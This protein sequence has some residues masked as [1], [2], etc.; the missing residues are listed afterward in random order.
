MLVIPLSVLSTTKVSIVTRY[1]R[2]VF[3]NHALH[4][5]ISSPKAE[6]YS[7]WLL[8]VCRDGSGEKVTF[9]QVQAISLVSSIA[10]LYVICV[11]ILFFIVCRSEIELP[12]QIS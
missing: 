10:A 9:Q 1:I 5:H 8:T 7:H 12:L 6:H 3:P 2:A 11:K 4:P